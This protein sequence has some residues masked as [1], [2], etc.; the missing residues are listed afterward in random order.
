MLYS[1]VGLFCATG[2]EIE[3]IEKDHGGG[4]EVEH[5]PHVIVGEGSKLVGCWD[6]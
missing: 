1:S 3:L 4:L 6:F 2:K 5:L